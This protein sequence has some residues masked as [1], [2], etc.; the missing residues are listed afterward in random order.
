MA[1]L[2]FGWDMITIVPLAAST[3]VILFS[4]MLNFFTNNKIV[5]DIN[6][7]F[8]RI[9]KIFIFDQNY[10]IFRHSSSNLPQFVSKGHLIIMLNL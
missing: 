6:E 5:K 4:E 2:A 8:K 1:P 3:L 9:F 10:L 7:S